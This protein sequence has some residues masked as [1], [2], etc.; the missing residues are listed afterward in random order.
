MSF[1]AHERAGLA[2]LADILI[3]ASEGFPSASEAGVA[4]E[5]LDQVLSFRPDVL[6]GLKNLL[7]SSRG[8]PP[9]EVVAELQKNDPAGFGLLAEIVPGA[10]FLNPQVRAKLGYAGQGPKAIDPHPDY[11]D[12]GLLQS[13]LDRGPIYRPTPAISLVS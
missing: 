13:V 3:P 8:R 2:G 10:Y 5:G 6:S 9:A 7:A 12:Q 11:L 1:D 4:A